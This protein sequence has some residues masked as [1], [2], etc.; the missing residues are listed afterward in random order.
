M[1]KVRTDLLLIGREAEIQR[2]RENVA[3]GRPTLLLGP[4]GLGKSQLLRVL[5]QALPRSIYLEQIR[6]L[7]VSLL[8]L[9][10]ALHREHHLILPG[11][12]PASLD[13][14][15]LSRKL[16]RL[17]VREL[18]EAIAGSL[19]ERGWVLILDQL[20]GLTP[21][22]A[23]TLERLL[24]AALVLGATSQLRPAL[25]KIWWAFDRIP[26]APLTREQARQLLWTLA[27]PDQIAD[28]A[29]FEARVLAQADGNPYALVEMVKQVAGDRPLGL[30]AIRDL[31]HG[32][33][34]RSLDITPALLLVGAGILAARFVALGLND[35]DL[36]IIA[37][38]LGALFFVAR[39]FVYRA[40]WRR[41]SGA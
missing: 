8:A 19:H 3:R 5:H 24:S 6:P 2:L 12:D 26:L 22:M 29:M 36:Y 18:T 9:C 25:Q 1:A 13:W 15:E 34:V 23:P 14:P 33:G 30:Q 4:V 32:A 17:N 16:S 38:S 41:G 21:S 10:Q 35:Q 37:G 40:L 28:P 39:Y 11:L 27:D 31:H 20:E 7:R